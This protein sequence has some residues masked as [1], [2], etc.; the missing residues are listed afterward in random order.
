[1]I[2]KNLFKIVVITL[3]IYSF[4]AHARSLPTPLLTRNKQIIALSL[5]AAYGTYSWYRSRCHRSI[6]LQAQSAPAQPHQ[7]FL[8]TVWNFVHGI[9]DNHKQVEKYKASKSTHGFVPNSI[10]ICLFDDACENLR[11]A[12]QQSQSIPWASL[13]KTR[14]SCLAQDAEI[15]KLHELVQKHPGKN[16]ILF[17]VSRG[18]STI[19]NYVALHKPGN[20]KA[21]ILESPFDDMY[22]V[23]NGI[24]RKIY[25]HWIPGLTTIGDLACA[26]IFN[27]YST[28]AIAPRDV[29][30]HMPPHIPVLIVCSEQDQLIPAAS[31]QALHQQLIETDHQQAFLLTLATGKHGHIITSDSGAEYR[32]AVQ[33][34]LHIDKTEIGA[35]H[36]TA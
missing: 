34:F 31:S 18:A 24:L 11:D 20:V 14:S 27:N 6:T 22:S 15:E 13:K 21:L 7:E 3:C 36:A 28:C 1:M 32:K 23:V 30:A 29:V 10:E 35:H 8:E 2:I 12:Y 33:D 17:G 16:L 25:A 5:L 26:T 19:I 9:A 4:N